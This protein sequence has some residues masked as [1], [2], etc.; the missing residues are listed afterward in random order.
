MYE[1]HKLVEQIK[2]EREVFEDIYT[3]GDELLEVKESLNKR[4]IVLRE[5]LLNQPENKNLNFELGFC[6][7]EVERIEEELKEFQNKYETKEAQ[8]EKHERIIEFN[9]K[10]LYSYLGLLKNLDVDDK[11]LD[12][13][14]TSIESL[15]KNITEYEYLHK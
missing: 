14:N 11:L 3:E 10:E 13:I 1:L 5:Q 15:D 7:M 8:I 6:E 9:L 4:I 12:A 2:H